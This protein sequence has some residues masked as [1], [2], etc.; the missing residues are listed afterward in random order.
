MTGIETP[1]GPIGWRRQ[2]LAVAMVLV[3]CAIAGLAYEDAARES[4][5]ALQDFAEEQVT[6]AHALGE[7]LGVDPKTL[8]KWLGDV[9]RDEDT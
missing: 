7:A 5:A 3:V 2:R 8:R 4:A 1:R 6:L 9:D